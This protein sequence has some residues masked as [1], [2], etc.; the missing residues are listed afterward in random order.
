MYSSQLRTVFVLF[1]L[2]H[3]NATDEEVKQGAQIPY[4]HR[5]HTDWPFD[6]LLPPQNGYMSNRE[7]LLHWSNIWL[8]A[9]RMVFSVFALTSHWPFEQLINCAEAFHSHWPFGHWP[10]NQP[11]GWVGTQ[12]M[13]SNSIKADQRF[14]EEFNWASLLLNPTQPDASPTHLTT[15]TLP[16]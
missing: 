16:S 6:G 3:Q 12:P 2:S 1:V 10:A 7:G 4:A 11:K 5:L 15:T 14:C 8:R 13:Q 9:Q